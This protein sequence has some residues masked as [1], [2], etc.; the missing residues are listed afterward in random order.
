MDFQSALDVKVND[1]VPPP[2]LPEGNYRW[3]VLREPKFSKSGDGEWNIC[4]FSVV[5]V[6]ALG[7]VDQDQL[8][9]FGDLRA[10]I[11]R[12][13]F[14]ASTD[15]EKKADFER[16]LDNIKKFVTR[17]LQL[18]PEEGQSLGELLSQTPNCEFIAQAVH[19]PDKKEE[20]SILYVD[21]KNWAAAD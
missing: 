14:M 7:D 3:K 13:S 19:R 12:V 1:I 20:S 10:G 8:E 6:E 4:E 15:P 16:A 2:P 9:K 11:N 21:V 5:P 18:E 17:A